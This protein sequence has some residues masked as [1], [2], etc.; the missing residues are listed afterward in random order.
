MVSFFLLHSPPVGLWVTRPVSWRKACIWP[1]LLLALDPAPSQLLCDCPPPP[2]LNQAQA[3]PVVPQYAAPALRA[4][5]KPLGN[6]SGEMIR[7]IPKEGALRVWASRGRF[8]SGSLIIGNYPEVACWRAAS[9]LGRC[10][11]HPACCWDGAGGHSLLTS[12]GLR[13]S[14]RRR[15]ESCAEQRPPWLLQGRIGPESHWPH[16]RGLQRAVGPQGCAPSSCP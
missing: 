16:L 5:H 14:L 13:C 11:S 8:V 4:V 3:L 15:L 2:T 10:S 1:F 12:W 9:F 6:P 7:R